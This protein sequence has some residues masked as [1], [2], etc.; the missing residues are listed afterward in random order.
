MRTSASALRRIHDGGGRGKMVEGRR[1][2]GIELTQ[3]EVGHGPSL[4]PFNDRPQVSSGGWPEV[5]KAWRASPPEGK[6]PVGLQPEA[7]QERRV[8]AGILREARRRCRRSGRS[9]RDARR[10]PGEPDGQEARRPVTGV[11]WDR[12]VRPELALHADHEESRSPRHESMHLVDPRPPRRVNRRVSPPSIRGP[13]RRAP[14]RAP[15]SSPNRRA[16][17]RSRRGGTG[18]QAPPSRGASP[19]GT[20]RRR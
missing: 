11:M 8:V 4:F 16:S 7:R 20:R 17:S 9:R 5:V 2:I 15:R 3:A 14:R 1:T 12:E 13:S 18:G 10:D 6:Y 19:F